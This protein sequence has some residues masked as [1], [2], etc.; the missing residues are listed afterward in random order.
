MNPSIVYILLLI[1]PI[2][3]AGPPVKF[4][5]TEVRKCDQPCR[6]RSIVFLLDTSGSIGQANFDRIKTVLSQLLPLICGDIQVAIMTFSSSLKMEF[7][8]N[9]FDWTSLESAINGILYRGGSTHTGKAI[10]CLN[11][12]ILSLSG[13]CQMNAQTDCLDIVVVTDGESNGPLEY[14]HSCTEMEW[15]RNNP[16]WHTMVNVHAI[17][18]GLGDRVEELDCLANSVD[19]FFSVDDI[20]ALETLLNEVSDTLLNNSHKF[21]CVEPACPYDF[22]EY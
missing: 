22:V 14:P 20:T 21:E 5:E 1:I 6:H 10:R 2:S 3:L 7:C 18:I 19:S 11:D 16:D 8:F 17:G 12:H 15:I 9:C 13:S 4:P